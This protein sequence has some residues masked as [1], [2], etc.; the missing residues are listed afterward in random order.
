MSRAARAGSCD[1][2]GYW[3]LQDHQSI[4]IIED[5][6][7]FRP[8]A[9]GVLNASGQMIYREPEQIGFRLRTAHK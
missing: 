3:W 5:D 6:G 2:E 4:E 7:A 8:R 9:T 1:D